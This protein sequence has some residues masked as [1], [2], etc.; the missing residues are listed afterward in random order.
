[1]DPNPYVYQYFKYG[2]NIFLV[3]DESVVYL[4]KIVDCEQSKQFL[5]DVEDDKIDLSLSIQ[6]NLKNSL[7]NYLKAL[8]MP[9]S[10]G[11][12]VDGKAF[13]YKRVKD[14]LEEGALLAV[15]IDEY[16]SLWLRGIVAGSVWDKL[17]TDYTII[18]DKIIMT[19]DAVYIVSNGSLYKID[20]E[21]NLLD[22]SFSF[23]LD[24]NP[25]EF[26]PE[27]TA[28]FDGPVV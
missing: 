24:P 13:E 28:D 10:N 2:D 8:K 23:A 18:D 27:V 14:D 15:L 6:K 20:F 16:G 12:F 9:I 1:M 25:F 19:N 21:F 4:G 22:Q 26:V 3:D 5:K 11:A 7:E 17:C